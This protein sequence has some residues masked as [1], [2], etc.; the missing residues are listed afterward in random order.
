MIGQIADPGVASAYQ[1][2][3]WAVAASARH[4]E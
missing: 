2:V 4:D 3:V 1:A